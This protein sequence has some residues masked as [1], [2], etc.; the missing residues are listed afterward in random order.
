VL[1]LAAERSGWGAPFARVRDGRRW[2]RGI[3]CNSY[4]D[5]TMV[6]QVAEVSAGSAGDVRVHRVVCAVDCGQPVNLSGIEGQFES[7][8]IWGLSAALK[9]E[10]TFERGRAVQGNYDAFPVIRM[11]EAPVVE[12]HV[13]P[14]D[15]PAFG[16]GEQPVPVVGPAVANA[17]FDATG[18]RLRRTPMRGA[19]LEA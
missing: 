10:I 6:A 14:S 11:N 5:R 3:A 15:L 7:G 1:Q 8:V 9:T 13:V 12:V 16:I 4:H 19:N 17:I 2:G 18:R